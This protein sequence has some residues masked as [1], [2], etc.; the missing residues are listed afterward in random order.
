MLHI[1]RSRARGRADALRAFVPSRPDSVAQ[2]MT[3]V[4]NAG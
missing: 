3:V 1:V 4:R 2:T